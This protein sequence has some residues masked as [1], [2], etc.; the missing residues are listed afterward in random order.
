MSSVLPCVLCFFFREL[1][2][3]VIPAY[4]AGQRLEF[5]DTIFQLRRDIGNSVLPVE[6]VKGENSAYG[7]AAIARSSDISF[8]PSNTLAKTIFLSRYY[9]YFCG[10]AFELIVD[11]FALRTFCRCWDSS[12]QRGR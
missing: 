5:L 12:L 7:S 9:F 3:F 11:C 1:A 10:M 6:P 8:E 4:S 2:G